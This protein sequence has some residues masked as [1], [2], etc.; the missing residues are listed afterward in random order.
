MRAYPECKKPS[1]GIHLATAMALSVDEM[2]TFDRSDLLKLNGK[3]LR[4]DGKPLT[5]CVPKAKPNPKLPSP[6]HDL[7]NS[8][9]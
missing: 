5:I 3:V 1:D 4:A 2:H 7:W 8:D 6:N 9:D